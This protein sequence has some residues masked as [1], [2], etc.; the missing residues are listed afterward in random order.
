MSDLPDF[1]QPNLIQAT[2]TLSCQKCNDDHRYHDTDSKSQ[3]SPLN[4]LPEFLRI[5]A[6]IDAEQLQATAHPS[7]LLSLLDQQHTLWLD[8]EI[9]PKTNALIDGAFVIDSHYWHF[10]N[11]QF[12]QH[13]F[14]IYHLLDKAS[15]LGGHHLIEFDLLFLY[16]EHIPHKKYRRFDTL[17]LHF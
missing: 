17:L 10:D 1:I 7:D 8:L 13:A 6:A 2:T 12:Y 14:F 16:F 4:S 3:A 5:H 15:F 9:N 11:K